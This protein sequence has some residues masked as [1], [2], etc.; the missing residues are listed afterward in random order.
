M[1]K[2]RYFHVFERGTI[3]NVTY[4]MQD[5]QLIAQNKT[6]L[7]GDRIRTGDEFV[8]TRKSNNEFKGAAM[9]TKMFMLSHRGL[10]KT[11]SN[12]RKYRSWAF[13]MFREMQSGDTT[14]VFGKSPVTVSANAQKLTNKSWNGRSPSTILMKKPMVEKTE[15]GQVKLTVPDLDPRNVCAP[16]NAT[17]M[18]ITL[19]LMCVSDYAY[20]DDTQ[21][22]EALNEE[23]EGNG[24]MAETDYIDLDKPLDSPVELT[25]KADVTST[26]SMA[27]IVAVGVTFY[28]QKSSEYMM[29]K[30]NSAY[31]NVL[32]V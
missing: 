8:N 19:L 5:G 20:S 1:A 10:E 29:M 27:T 28:K 9:A 3:G 23:A 18:K 11:F 2:A 26:E 22:Y 14:T 12:S 32:A 6:S 30:K 25:A 7:T 15:T 16:S 13:K 17:H 24:A 4:R 21:L 31:M